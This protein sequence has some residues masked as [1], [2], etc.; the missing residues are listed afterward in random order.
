VT[1]ARSALFSRPTTPATMLILVKGHFAREWQPCHWSGAL[2]G[3]TIQLSLVAKRGD[4]R[5][6][7]KQGARAGHIACGGRCNIERRENEIE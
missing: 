6:R 3:Q 2:Y 7:V 4:E 1:T 5:Q